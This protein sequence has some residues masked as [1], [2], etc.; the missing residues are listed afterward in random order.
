MLSHG[1]SLKN[2]LKLLMYEI[3]IEEEKYASTV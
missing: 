2:D 1:I 3:I